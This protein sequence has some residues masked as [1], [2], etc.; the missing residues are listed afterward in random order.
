MA[1][2]LLPHKQ[3]GQM[4]LRNIVFDNFLRGKRRYSELDPEKFSHR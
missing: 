2:K 3:V 1:R 4:Y